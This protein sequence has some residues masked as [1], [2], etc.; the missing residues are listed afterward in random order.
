MEA[1]RLKIEPWR[2][3][4]PVFV[5]SH[6]FD[7]KQVKVKSWIRFGIYIMVIRIRNPSLEIY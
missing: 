6:H 1:W 2:V 5:D 3:Y 7:E 4:R